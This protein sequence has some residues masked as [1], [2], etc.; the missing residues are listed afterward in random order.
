[1]GRLAVPPRWLRGHHRGARSPAALAGG[2][3]A[4]RPAGAVAGELPPAYAYLLD[5]APWNVRRLAGDRLPPGYLARLDR[6]PHAPAVFKLDYALSGPVPWRDPSCRRAGTVHVGG[7]YAEIAAGLRA[8]ARGELPQQPFLITTQP[9]L[10]DDS[11]APRGAHTF[12]AYTHVPLGWRGDLTEAIE[13]RLERFAPGFRDLVLARRAA[14]PAEIER[15]NRNDVGGDIGGGAFGWHRAFFRPLLQRVPYATPDP[16][17]F[18]CSSA[19]PPGPGVHGMCGY[20]AAQVV[21]RR[22]FRPGRK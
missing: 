15:R 6:T 12:W 2:R 17:L 14:G 20:H 4:H 19:T 10:F 11:R 3:A 5:A 21:L 18:L 16:S 13:R 8:A 9:S 22:V 7:S 1:R